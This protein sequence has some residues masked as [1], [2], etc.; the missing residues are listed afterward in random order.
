[1]QI[2]S[3]EPITRLAYQKLT[4]NEKE[5]FWQSEIELLK[6]SEISTRKFC[7]SRFYSEHTFSYWRKKL[8]NP[9]SKGGFK[10]VT[11]K[12]GPPSPASGYRLELTTPS[13]IKIT[14][15]E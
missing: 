7:S 6:K 4:N 11:I 14:V 12:E 1:M 2:P 5:D 9:K 15:T 8:N 10:K 13:G 3:D